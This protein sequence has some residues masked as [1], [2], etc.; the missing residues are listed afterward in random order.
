MLYIKIYTI[1]YIPYGIYHWAYGIYQYKVVYTMTQ[2]SRWGGRV[3]PASD[4]GVDRCHLTTMIARS[5][6]DSSIKTARTMMDTEGL[7][8][9]ACRRI[10]CHS[11]QRS[12]RQALSGTST[13]L[14]G[15]SVLYLSAHRWALFHLSRVEP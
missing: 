12:S 4:G 8:L 13:R 9:I 10:C 5:N 11:G 14:G 7:R 1:W 3:S 2:P 15:R 6:H